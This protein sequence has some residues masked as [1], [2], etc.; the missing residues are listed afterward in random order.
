MQYPFIFTGV[1]QDA[2]KL[3]KVNNAL[4]FLDKFLEGEKYAAGKCLTVADL[5]LITTISNYKVRNWF[6]VSVSDHFA[7]ANL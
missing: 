2:M 3:E 5:A 1:T 6:P 4:S 7:A